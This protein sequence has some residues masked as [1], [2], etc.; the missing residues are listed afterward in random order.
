MLILVLDEIDGLDDI[1]MV[2]G[3][4][5]TKLCGEFLDVFLL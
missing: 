5:N 4:R 3:G 1:D 2:Q